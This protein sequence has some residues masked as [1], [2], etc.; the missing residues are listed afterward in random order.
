MFAVAL[1]HS[2]REA[3]QF[4]VI[5]GSGLDAR[6]WPD[7]IP[8]NGSMHRAIGVAANTAFAEPVVD[9]TVFGEEDV[10]VSDDVLEYFNWAR[11]VF[12]D[13][14]DVLAVCA[15]SVGGQ[16][17]D[18][19]APA[20]DANVSQQAVL[21]LPYYNAWCWGTWRDRWQKIL[22]PEWDWSGTSGGFDDSG[23]DWNIQSRI[24]PRH[25]MNCVV[26][27]ASRSQ[28]IGRHE[29]VYSTEAS[30]SFAEAASFREHRPKLPYVLV[31]VT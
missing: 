17:W 20:D 15:H 2:D 5:E 27:A 13:R 4:E 14:D 30:F 10:L 7:P 9:F 18:K 23:Y 6:I 3:E 11:D 24:L 12:R 8:A 29:G 25:R 31:G 28:N 21:V 26:P 16:G 22:E 1:G 19:H